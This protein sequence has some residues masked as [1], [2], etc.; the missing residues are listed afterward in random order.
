MPD[1]EMPVNEMLEIE[2]FSDIICPWCYIGKKRLDTVMASPLGEQ[3][4]L[5]WRPYQLYPNL[6]A[7][8]L[9][10]H[11]Q[12]R[13]R[14]GA[15]AD[16]ARVP[17]RIAVESRQEGLEFRYDLI[18]RTPNTMAAHRLMELAY[19][20]DLQHELA[21]ALFQ[22]HFCDGQDVGDHATL[23][24]IAAAVGM[25]AG[26]VQAFLDAGHGEQEVRDQLARA[27]EVGVSGVPGY[28]LKIGATDGPGYLLPGAQ[29]ADVM[30]QIFGRALERMHSN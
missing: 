2:I 5:R 24:Q 29:A 9:D 13:H 20:Q 11:E 7:E 12:L 10:R 22:A 8:G 15:N 17:E 14:Y 30:A 3:I 4:A 21:E 25:D 28:Y 19:L 18:N 23:T 1:K 27:P 26:N 6:P 16:P